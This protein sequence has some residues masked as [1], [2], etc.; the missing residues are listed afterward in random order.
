MNRKFT[1]GARPFCD[2][3]PSKTI[4]VSGQFVSGTSVVG[5]PSEAGFLMPRE[6][7]PGSTSVGSNLPDWTAV[8]PSEG[9]PPI[10]GSDP[11][12]RSLV[13]AAAASVPLDARTPRLPAA[14]VTR[15][16]TM[17]IMEMTLKRGEL[18]RAL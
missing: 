2:V 6:A 4:V 5:A 7:G 11:G 15:R 12:E 9:T 13:R 1:T 8:D 18:F 10:S 14:P 16:Q 17:A 3:D